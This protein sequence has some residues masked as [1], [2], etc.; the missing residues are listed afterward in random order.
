MSPSKS[1]T[2]ALEEFAEYDKFVRD[3]CKFMSGTY[4]ALGLAGETGEVVERIKKL[5]RRYGDGWA[6]NMDL[7]DKEGI[8][9]EMGDV[10]WY[11]TR[12]SQ[13]CGVTLK[14]VLNYNMIKLQERQRDGADS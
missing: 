7:M 14:N 6:E 8:I 11:I 2:N 9:D 4:A 13:L 12:L 1:T 10:L 3:T 5:H